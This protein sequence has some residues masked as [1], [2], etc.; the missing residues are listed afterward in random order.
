M[1]KIL[2]I[3]DSNLS[4]RTMRKILEAAGHEVI[5]A[6]EGIQALEQYYLHHPDLVFLDL[7]M[8]G[9]SGFEVLRILRE[10]DS[11]ARVIVATADLQCATQEEAMAGGAIAYIKKPLTSDKVL[12]ALQTVLEGGRNAIDG[13]PE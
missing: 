5:D 3:D 12:Q 6:G 4:R 11:Q 8:T 1:A 2:I 10:M 13:T 9:M 7:M